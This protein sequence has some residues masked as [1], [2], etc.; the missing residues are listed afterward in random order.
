MAKT[1]SKETEVAASGVSISPLVA[2]QAGTI[3]LDGGPAD[4]DVLFSVAMPEGGANETTVHT[5]D[6]GHAEMEIVPNSLGTLSVAVTQTTIN[7]IGS[8]EMAVVGSVA[9]PPLALEG[10]DPGSYECGPP[11]NFT[12]LI[13]GTGFDINTRASFGIFSQEEADE[14]LGEVGAPKWE[15]GTRFV[16]STQLALPISAGQFPGPDPDIPVS[17]GQPDGDVAG[18]VSFAFTPPAPPDPVGP[19]PETQQE[20]TDG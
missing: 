20:E 13:N 14:G 8:A 11:E 5:D 3:S 6:A 15:L 4:T 17:V 16:S 10:L 7:V 1:A 2:Y 19:Q 12:L 18:P 9:P